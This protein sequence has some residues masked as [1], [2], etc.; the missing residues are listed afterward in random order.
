MAVSFSKQ[1]KQQQRILFQKWMWG[2]EKEGRRKLFE[3]I[4]KRN[5]MG[6]G[7]GWPAET[8]ASSNTKVRGFGIN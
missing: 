5:E 8:N 1:E 4:F 7:W 6:R 3:Q 2:T